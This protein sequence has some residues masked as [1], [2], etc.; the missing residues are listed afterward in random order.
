MLLEVDCVSA[1]KRG[2]KW[3]TSPK[4][5]RKKVK[6][7]LDPSLISS[8]S[9]LSPSPNMSLS[10]WTYE[11][12]YDES[13]FPSRIYEAR[14]GKT[15]CLTTDGFEDLGLQSEPILYQIL[16]LKRVK[17]KR[18]KKAFYRLESKTIKVGCTCV[19]PRVI[20]QM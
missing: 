18:G 7:V 20:P 12:T 17:P 4:S 1:K 19:R 5:S 2:D 16:V 9:P 11:Y 14:C 15:G 8:P 13:R 10:P 3:P 6:L